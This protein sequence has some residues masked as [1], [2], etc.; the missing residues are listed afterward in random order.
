MNDKEKLIELL[1]SGVRCP[2]TVADCT[3]CPHFS[4]DNPCDEFAATADMLISNGVI[5]QK[6]GRWKRYKNGAKE[7]PNCG[8]MFARLH[9]DHYC[10]N[11]GAKMDKEG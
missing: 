7:C 1:H 11:C 3:D 10:P 4:A 5:V 6:R 8:Y 2:G 9:P